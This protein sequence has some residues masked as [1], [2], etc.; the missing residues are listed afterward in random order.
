[1][2]LFQSMD[3]SASALTAGRLR[4]EVIAENL[5]N[6]HTTRTAAGGPFRRKIV[7][8]A[9]QGEGTFTAMVGKALAARLPA[10]RGS[11]LVGPPDRGWGGRA[12]SA[13][14]RPGG[15]RVDGIYGDP[16]PFQKVYDP[17]HPDAGEDGFVLMPNVNLVEEMVELVSASRA[18]EANVTAFNATR[19][20]A[21]RAL[22]I[23]RG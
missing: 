20:M 14:R 6:I 17:S 23:G 8:M 13:G 10:P 9:P 2:G 19:H 12:G 7:T 1:M 4:L 5:A 18:Y 11:V 3:T 15:V 21:M 16:R 22:E